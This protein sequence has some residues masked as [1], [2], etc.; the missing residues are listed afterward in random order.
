MRYP[1][2]LF[3]VLLFSCASGPPPPKTG[4]PPYYWQSAMETYAKADYQKTLEHLS[5]IVG[6]DNE[7][8]ARAQPLRLILSSG[9]LRGYA[10]LADRFEDGARAAK[11]AQGP[12]RK[13]AY[14]CRGF[15]H[16]L[17]IQL[18]EVWQQ[19]QKS[20]PSGDVTINFPYPA[21]GGLIVPPQITRIAE[22]QTLP[23]HDIETAETTMLQRA[24]LQE[25]ASAVGAPGDAPKAQEILK[26]APVQT[27]RAAFN[28]AMAK[29]FHDAAMM[30]VASKR[31]EPARQEF[32]ADQ[33][34][35]A[36]EG[37]DKA[38]AKEIREKLE[39]VLRDAKARK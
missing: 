5:K 13:R 28:L 6:S 4:T 12:F 18:S 39:K 32:L 7:F 22:G 29:V 20:N 34:L 9:L 23:D 15:A 3:L 36:L 1:T 27:P 2:S 30:Y 10:E 26:G 19:Y 37:V 17:G 14:D 24:V 38:K 35:K 21:R 33:G 31:S 16:T 11:G 25:V 8:T